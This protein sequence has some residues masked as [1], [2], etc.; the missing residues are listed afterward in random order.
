MKET[1]ETKAFI[2]DFDIKMGTLEIHELVGQ[3]GILL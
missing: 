2:S 3:K 1:S